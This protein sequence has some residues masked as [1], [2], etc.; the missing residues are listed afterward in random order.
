MSLCGAPI[1]DGMGKP[2]PCANELPCAVHPLQ[3]KRVSVIRRLMR[4]RDEALE[5]LVEVF[6]DEE[7]VRV[8]VCARPSPPSS[9]RR[10]FDE[11]RNED[12]A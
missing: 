2:V 12:E 4:S 5:V 6:L 10:P 9:F 3:K 11:V 7:P 1:D 8:R